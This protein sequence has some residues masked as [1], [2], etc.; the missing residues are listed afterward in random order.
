MIEA[1]VTASE[2][3][4]ELKEVAVANKLAWRQAHSTRAL[5]DNILAQIAVH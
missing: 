1:L 4:R 3:Y 5:L 2:Q